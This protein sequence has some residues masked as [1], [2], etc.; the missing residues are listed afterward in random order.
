M[1][2]ASPAAEV[3]PGID[4]LGRVLE[5][6]DSL[7]TLYAPVGSGRDDGCFISRSYD[8]TSHFESA[9]MDGACVRV[10]VRGEEG[11]GGRGGHACLSSVPLLP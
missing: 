11:R 6:F 4:L 3:Q 2:T 5:R 1:E 10:C 8:A 7:S 9:A